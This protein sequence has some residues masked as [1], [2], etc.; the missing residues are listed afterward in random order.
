V[1]WIALSWL[2]V[3]VGLARRRRE[4]RIPAPVSIA[5]AY[6]APLAVASAL[7]RGR[8]RAAITWA[9]HMW[10]Y[11]IAFEVPYDRPERLRRRLHID[12]PIR[13]DTFLGAGIPPSVRLQRALR[14][15]PELTAL[16]RAL[17]GVYAFWD[18]EPH[19]ALASILL[20]DP[21]RF[22]AAA[23]RLGL[24]FDSTLLGYFLYPSAPPWW[25]SEREGRLDTA[26]RRVTAEVLKELRG[27]PRPGTDHSAG[28]NPW[29]A[30]PSDHFATAVMAS[31]IL[32]D[33]DARAAKAAAAYAAAL[34]L[35]L[36]YTG[37][38]YVAD[39]LAG[40][41]TAAAADRLV[42]AVPGF[43]RGRGGKA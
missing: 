19:L 23:A 24:T 1:R 15:P 18:V 10:A 2:P 42:S 7:P 39:L 27:K 13:A 26:V 43:N 33:S 8:P 9:A 35:A 4:L 16:D 5:I 31:V 25:A 38:H 3:A 22:P 32:A 17:T 6:S 37:E 34:G 14:R 36:V 40:L 11:K 28:A 21:G 12:A 20:R 41:A 30:M 29:A